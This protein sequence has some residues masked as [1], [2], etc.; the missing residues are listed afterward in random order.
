M[1]RDSLP[2]LSR[3]IGI[4]FIFALFLF[5]S[6]I[7]AAQII[8]SPWA[9]KILSPTT[10]QVPLSGP[11][12]AQLQFSDGQQM[13]SDNF[14]LSVAAD[15]NLPAAMLL[16]V[17]TL[18]DFASV[19]ATLAT[20][21]TTRG[22]LEIQLFSTAAPLTVANFVSLTKAGFYNHLR[23]HRVEPGFVVQVGDPASREATTAAQLSQLG[24]GY[25]G[26]RIM[27]EISP[28]LSHNQKGI[29]SMAN[30]NLTGDYPNSGG[31]QFFITLNPATYLDG[32]YSI[33]GQVVKGLEVLDQL[34]VGDQIIKVSLK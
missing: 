24:T 13:S 14:N 5:L 32:R 15:S 9:Q 23:F 29:L 3:A 1:K 4:F 25:P 22:D 31:S 30:I 34:T 10:T 16:P 7:A 2:F 6:F 12:L 26:Y 27:D 21:K 33:F 28:A 17:K 19:S 11:E 8:K 18:A 20:I